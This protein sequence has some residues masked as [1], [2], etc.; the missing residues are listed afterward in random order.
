VLV[1][2]IIAVAVNADSGRE[3][4]GMSIGPLKPNPIGPTSS[5][6]SLAAGST[7]SS[8][9][10]RTRNWESKPPSRGCSL[11]P[12]KGLLVFSRGRMMGILAIHG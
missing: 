9:L 2:V 4:L 12:L 3:V 1:A 8:W 11:Q 10:S 5:A 7:A 6:N